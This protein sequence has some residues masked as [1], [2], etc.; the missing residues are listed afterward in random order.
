MCGDWLGSR[1]S[2][3]I[4]VQRL[5][6]EPLW[7]WPVQDRGELK[8]DS[9]PSL[10]GASVLSG[11][12]GEEGT[13]S[14]AFSLAR[15]QPTARDSTLAPVSLSPGGTGDHRPGS[16]SLCSAG[17]AGGVA[18]G[19]GPAAKSTSFMDCFPA[20]KSVMG[21]RYQSPLNGSSL[22]LTRGL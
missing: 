10:V 17:F 4:L 11:G 2:L 1:V 12:V 8:G 22:G 9:W 14:P 5:V 18:D 16:V 13:W 3:C 21:L 20:G 15:D 19:K 7:G 6:W